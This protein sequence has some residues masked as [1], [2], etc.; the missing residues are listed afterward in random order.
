MFWKLTLQTLFD[1]IK[2]QACLLDYLSQDCAN[3]GLMLMSVLLTKLLSELNLQINRKYGKDIWNIWEVL[4]LINLEIGAREKFIVHEK[5]S[6]SDGIFSGSALI[7][8]SN[9]RN[10]K[11]CTNAKK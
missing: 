10:I 1:I 3:Y 11:K 4:N 7:S 9:Q 6:E 2:T 8:T 5:N